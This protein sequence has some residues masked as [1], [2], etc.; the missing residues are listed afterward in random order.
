MANVSTVTPGSS[1][2]PDTIN[3]PQLLPLFEYT[4][5]SVH[6]LLLESDI[7]TTQAGDVYEVKL[8]GYYE[9]AAKDKVT[10]PLFEHVTFARVLQGEL[11][12][13]EQLDMP[14][15]AVAIQSDHVNPSGA[16]FADQLRDAYA[17]AMN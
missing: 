14:V 6:W 9:V 8:Y 4:A 16:S 2:N 10:E 17:I 11:S 7:E 5:D 3:P 13:G 1:G 12:M 15:T